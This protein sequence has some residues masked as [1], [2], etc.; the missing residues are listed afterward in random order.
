VLHSVSPNDHISCHFLENH[1]VFLVVHGYEAA[2]NKIIS[3][4]DGSYTLC[5]LQLLSLVLFTA[6]CLIC[7]FDYS[8]FSWWHVQIL[9]IPPL[10][11][12]HGDKYL[13]AKIFAIYIYKPETKIF[14]YDLTE[15][16]LTEM[17]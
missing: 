17:L 11:L 14:I 8:P 10:S 4:K 7:N 5:E 6:K 16:L 9:F 2:V 13:Y 1:K 15:F 12:G 3:F